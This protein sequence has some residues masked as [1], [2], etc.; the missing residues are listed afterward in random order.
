MAAGK[1]TAPQDFA[2]PAVGI[3]THAHLDLK[4]L[5]RD[6]P[7]A[8]ERA[9]AAGL[10]GIGNVFLGP[11]AYRKH[12][13]LF[14]EHPEVF[15]V[16]GIHPH[17]AASVSDDSLAEVER[18]VREDSRIKALGET[19]LDFFHDRSPRQAQEQGFQAQLRLARE[20]ELPVVIHS[21]DADD[22][23]VKI[24]L[25][26]GF[27]D[28]PLM[29]HCFG[30]EAAFAEEIVSYGWMISLPGIVT[31]SKAKSVQEAVNRIPLARMVLETDCPFLAPEP[32]RGKT[33]EPAYT[34]FTAARI[35]E[36]SGRGIEEVWRVTAENAASF[37]RL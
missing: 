33:N 8:L 5:R 34:V 20:L 29:W 30:R 35:A 16:L 13:A 24:L 3:D 19:G 12:A 22:Q 32:Y 28:R 2:L 26:E 21:R 7:G 1:R 14:A 31:F 4:P 25:Q 23:T 6:V 11:E 36:L 27:R 9:K 10:A 37:F 15:F 18:A 17:E